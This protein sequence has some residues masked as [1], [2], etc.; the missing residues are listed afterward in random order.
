MLASGKLSFPDW[1]QDQFNFA[2][3]RGLDVASIAAQDDFVSDLQ[4]HLLASVAP[5]TTYD[6][7]VFQVGP[8]PGA[9]WPLNT[10]SGVANLRTSKF[11]IASWARVVV[12][13]DRCVAV[14]LVT[15]GGVDPLA[16]VGFNAGEDGTHFVGVLDDTGTVTSVVGPAV[17]DN[18]HRW[19]V[20]SDAVN[21]HFLIDGNEIGTLPVAN[22][23]NV[24]GQLAV[25]APVG[26]SL[27]E[28]LVDKYMLAA[29]KPTGTL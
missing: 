10:Q 15:P 25:M 20:L 5:V 9:I 23:P 21:Y 6:G 22:A 2:K 17:D 24:S 16:Y 12:A 27:D 4:S 19:I 11:L 1:F 28:L 26:T 14:G 13:D 18:W 7:G 29:G 3:A 8:G